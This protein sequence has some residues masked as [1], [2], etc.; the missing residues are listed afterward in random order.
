MK[1][2]LIVIFA[3]L[4]AFAL[5]ACAKE[6][7]G[8]DTADAESSGGKTSDEQ[9][10]DD[11]STDEQS[12]GG[13]IS[14][15]DSDGDPSTYKEH[16]ADLWEQTKAVLRTDLSAGYSDE[17]YQAIG[18][19]LDIVW[20]ELQVHASLA[21]KDEA[22]AADEDTAYANL[23]G[24]IKELINKEYGNWGGGSAEDREEKR[25]SLRDGGLERKISDIDEI[26]YADDEG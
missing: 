13:H 22:D 1:K 6:K 8:S 20:S 21:H 23:V 26:V 16:V 9:S 10:P 25:E 5:T 12:P 17:E 7:S 24:D 15:D 14:F 11:I 18:N 3:L 2:V 4:L 19:A